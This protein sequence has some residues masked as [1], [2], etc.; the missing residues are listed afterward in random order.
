MKELD[1]DHDA[2][3]NWKEVPVA[4]YY[5]RPWAFV[6]GIRGLTVYFGEKPPLSHYVT[7]D[8]VADLSAAYETI[9]RRGDAD[10]ITRW[11]LSVPPHS[12][13]TEAREQ[14]RG[15]LLLFERLAEYGLS[16][17]ADGQ[18]RFRT[19]L[20]RVFDWSVLPQHLRYW[21]PWLRKFE[22]LRGEHQLLSYVRDADE[23]RVRELAELCDLLSR[24]GEE[25]SAWCELANTKGHPAEYEA[26]QAEWLFVLVDFFE[27]RM[28]P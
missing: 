5:L 2:V 21:E 13:A 20:P 6:F 25:L 8:E 1:R 15:L 23:T 17:F 24:N 19:R 10:A 27:S 16:P 14:I 26:F 18:V 11:C 9:S 12:P 22:S 3:V 28:V 7:D 4:F